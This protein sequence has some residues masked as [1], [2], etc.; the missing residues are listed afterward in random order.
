MPRQTML[1]LR[2][3]AGNYDGINW[4]RGALYEQPALDYAQRRG[5]A[6]RVLDVAGKADENSA[7]TVMAL[8]EF[9]RDQTIAAFYGFSGGGY[10][11]KHILDK[12]TPEE[13]D[14]VQLVVVLGAPLNKASKYEASQYKGGHWELVYRLDPPKAAGGH[15]GGPAALLKDTPAGR[16]RDRPDVED[17]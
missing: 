2:G 14:R 8:T 12:L 13:R 16:Y 4:P 7:Q 15:M 5:Y 17:D 3:I 10:N 11:V 9:R 6:G 1:I